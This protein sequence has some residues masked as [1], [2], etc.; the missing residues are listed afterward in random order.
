VHEIFAFRSNEEKM[1]M[2]DHFMEL[3]SRGTK[4][5]GWGEQ[6]PSI[7]DLIQLLENQ[8]N[9]IKQAL[10]FRLKEPVEHP[11]TTY[12]GSLTLSKVEEF[13]SFCLYHEGIHIKAIKSIKRIIQKSGAIVE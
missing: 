3:F 6:M 7:N 13:L 1:E 4:P 11:F 2:A 12:T 8:V 5:G 10:K 9:R